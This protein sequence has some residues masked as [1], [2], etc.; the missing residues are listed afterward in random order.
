LDNTALAW[1]QENAHKWWFHNSYQKGVEIDGQVIEPWHRRYVWIK[2]ATE[3]YE[4]KQSFTEWYY[5]LEK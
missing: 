2:L 4:K 5:S 3:L 1:L